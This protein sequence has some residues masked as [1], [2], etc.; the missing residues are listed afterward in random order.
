MRSLFNLGFIR[1]WRQ[2]HRDPFTSRSQR[3]NHHARSLRAAIRQLERSQETGPRIK[4][5]V[6][7]GDSPKVRIQEGKEQAST[8]LNPGQPRRIR[9]SSKNQQGGHY[10]AMGLRKWDPAGWLGQRL[11][12][13]RRS[14]SRQAKDQATASPK[15]AT[16]VFQPAPR[17]STLLR[18][19]RRLARNRFLFMFFLLLALLSA[20]LFMLRP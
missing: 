7:P 9:Q 10:N 18:R 15:A 20:I 16:G 14:Q 17:V 3:L 13:M 11:I 6:A 4:R 5:S 12:S 8:A 19:E 2:G 1:K